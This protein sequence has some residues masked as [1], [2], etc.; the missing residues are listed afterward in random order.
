[1]TPRS[2]WWVAHE[3]AAHLRI[4]KQT[5]YNEVK[6]GR[7]RAARIGGRRSLRFLPEWCDEY[8]EAQSTPVEVIPVGR[9]RHGVK[10]V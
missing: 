5:L 9:I 4:S 2:P 7:L 10:A 1:M 6:H 3:A 8:L